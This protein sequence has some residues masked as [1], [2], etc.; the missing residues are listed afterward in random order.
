MGCS[1]ERQ[2][3]Y[4]NYLCF[5]KHLDKSNC[6]PNKTWSDK[7]SEFLNRSMKSCLQDNDIEIYL[8][9]Q[10]G[11]NYLLKDLLEPR[12]LRFTSI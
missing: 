6:K 2:K 9:P 3:T 4:Y 5:S 7:R 10:E 1:F 12:A 8:T 11:K